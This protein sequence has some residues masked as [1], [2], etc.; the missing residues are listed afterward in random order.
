MK[1]QEICKHCGTRVD[2]AYG[3]Y[4]NGKFHWCT[5]Y[6][7]GRAYEILGS[8]PSLPTSGANTWF[9]ECTSYPKIA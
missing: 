3:E 6:A 9:Y 7:W 8:R 4:F 1:E 5:W 2:V